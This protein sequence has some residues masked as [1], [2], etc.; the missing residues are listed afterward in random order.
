LS[1]LAEPAPAG[2]AAFQ[3]RKEVINHKT[4]P[5]RDRRWLVCGGGVRQRDGGATLPLRRAWWQ[6]VNHKTVQRRRQDET[7]A[8]SSA[9]AQLH[10][11]ISFF[12]CTRG[13]AGA[14]RRR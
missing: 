8:A 14:G 1:A 13:S 11:I 2:A 10:L 3:G 12:V 4:V 7:G 5:R 9:A 6:V